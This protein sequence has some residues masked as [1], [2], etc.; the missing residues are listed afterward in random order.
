MFLPD[1]LQVHP[2][3]GVTKSGPRGDPTGHT[4]EFAMESNTYIES[5]LMRLLCFFNERI[6]FFFIVV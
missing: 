5:M 3:G 1:F 2:C 6:L 4:S